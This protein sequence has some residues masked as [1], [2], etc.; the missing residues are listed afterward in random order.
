[1]AGAGAQPGL[2]V[3]MKR[4]GARPAVQETLAAEGLK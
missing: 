1:M 4:I 3:C 2:L